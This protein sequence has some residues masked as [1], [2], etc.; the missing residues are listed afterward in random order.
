MGNPWDC[1]AEWASQN[2]KK[3]TEAA[4]NQIDQTASAIQDTAEKTA[5]AGQ[6]SLQQMQQTTADMAAQ[7]GKAA[8][9]AKTAVD[10]Q[11]NG[12]TSSVNKMA[13]GAAITVKA[14]LEQLQ[15]IVAPPGNRD[16]VN[17]AQKTGAMAQ[18]SALQAAEPDLAQTSQVDQQDQAQTQRQAIANAWEQWQAEI[19]AAGAAGMV[20]TQA[21]KD[22]PRTAQALAQEMP[23]LARRLQ[24]AGVRSGDLPRAPEDVMAL[25]DKIP[26]TS[27]LGNS[28]TNIRIFLS[29]KHGSHIH[30]HSQGGGNGADNIVWELGSDNIRR[31][32]ET[33]TGGEQIYIRCYNAVDSIVKN[34]P[35]IAS[36]GLQA[37][38]IA[39][40]TQ[41]VVTALSY[42]LDLQRGD[43][44]VEEFRDK[45]IAAAVQAGIATPI[46]FLIFVV[47]MA[48][49][50][51]LVAILTFPA[52]VA[53]FNAL[54]VV[55]IAL[56]IIQSIIRHV[57][58]DGFGPEVRVQ[59]EMATAQGEAMLQSASEQVQMW[60]DSLFNL[61]GEN[62][63][64]AVG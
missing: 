39:I 48:L 23:K 38:G 17:P 60:W 62:P 28:E 61:D 18:T 56:P 35:T 46:F 64:A 45:I 40:I 44:T 14:S 29:D 1:A 26:G 9:D 22:L 11:V 7:V 15:E 6:A 31:G 52:V 43:I 50:P 10:E 12:V 58:A 36:L 5:S 34:S 49:I 4:S 54:F 30:P 20:V 27:K 42:A 41:T 63:S 55:G 25:F 21:L 37:T 16:T 3:V 8:A 53:G 51:E 33:M 57:E 59:Y 19:L 24:T 2:A 13:E 47:V 32:A